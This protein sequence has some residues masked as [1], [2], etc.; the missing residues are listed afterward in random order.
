VLLG[1]T[2]LTA[3]AVVSAVPFLPRDG[4]EGRGRVAIEETAI[5]PLSDS[6]FAA[7]IARVAEPGGFFDSD[8]L[9]SNETG[10][11]QP[12]PRMLERGVLGG[13]YI[14][15]GPDQNYS[16]IAHVQPEIAFMLDIRRDA[17]LQHLLYKQLFAAAR[18]RL[19]YLCL[20]MAKPVPNDIERWQDRS[21][22]ELVG[23]L[24][25]TPSQQN[26][27]DSTVTAVAARLGAHAAPVSATELEVVARIQREFYQ[28]G[29]ELRYTSRNRPSRRGYPSFRTLIQ[30]RD[31]NGEQAGYLAREE[32][33]QFVKWLHSENRIVPV[34]GNLAG[35][36][37]LREIG[38]YVKEAGL[39]VSAMYVS[40][41]EMYLMRDRVFDAFARNLATLPHDSTTVIIRSSFSNAGYYYSA[42]SRSSG[43]M[44]VQL[45]Q[46]MESF[47]REFRGG[48]YRTYADVTRKHS[49]PLQ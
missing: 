46:S 4:R 16:Y 38:R 21:I 29:L 42:R 24:D 41:V 6:A 30:E 23:Y 45:L 40:N 47:V 37:A 1:A 18:N 32:Y 28:H 10:Y 26:Q 11:L 31:L 20:L 44:S 27:F 35:P 7:L 8:N 33:F 43:S 19:E 34:T 25:R 5:A 2:I 15:V 39:N 14:G 12:L 22:T 36:K 17:G 48:G 3:V 13:A 49:I 9:V